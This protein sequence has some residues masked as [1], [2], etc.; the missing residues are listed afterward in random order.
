MKARLKVHLIQIFLAVL[1]DFI[2]GDPKNLP[3]PVRWIGSFISFLEKRIYPRNSSFSGGAFLV[4]IT[5][6]VSLGFSYG[7]IKL[8][9][10]IHSTLSLLVG[11]LLVFYS[12][13][14][15]SLKESASH[16]KYLLEQEK[17]EEARM[18]VGEIV[19][20]DTEELNSQE[21]VR[22]T[23]ETV[24][25][26]ASDGVVAPLIYALV[27]GPFLAVFYRVANTL[28]SMVGYRNERYSR[29]GWLSAR[30]DDLLNLFPS[31][32]TA[33]LFL[34]A[35]TLHG[36][37][38]F[39]L[40]KILF[41]DAK[42]HKSP[43]AGW[44]EAAMAGLLGVRLGGINYYRGKLTFCAFLGEPFNS[45][46]PSKIGEALNYFSLSYTLFLLFLF[47]IGWWGVW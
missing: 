42:R 18:K 6:F 34:L 17:L 37:K 5:L 16:V 24:A 13:S 12:I 35:G 21:V 20:R 36:K 29:F 31:R 33:L 38:P 26:N 19:G 47:L 4:I 39:Y 30:L 1:L 46:V 44:P 23:I 11:A 28:D 14:F 9:E 40:S 22:A 3:H 8:A 43:N 7:F 32:F 10:A 2:I 45:L 15:K 41:R 25:E 27:G